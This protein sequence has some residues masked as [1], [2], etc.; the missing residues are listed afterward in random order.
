[1]PVYRRTDTHWNKLGALVAYNAV[2]RRARKPEWVID[3]ARVL[4]A[5]SNAS[6]AAISPGCSQSRP[7]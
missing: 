2:V 4:Q 7:T 6:R 1:M 3:P 5:A